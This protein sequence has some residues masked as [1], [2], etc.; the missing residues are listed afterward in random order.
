MAYEYNLPPK[1]LRWPFLRHRE[2]IQMFIHS[3]L[4]FKTCS[5]LLLPPPPPH[6]EHRYISRSSGINPEHYPE[7][8]PLPS[9][10]SRSFTSEPIPSSFVGLLTSMPSFPLP[11]SSF[12]QQAFMW[13]LLCAKCYVEEKMEYKAALRTCRHLVRRQT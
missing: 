8:C 4:C 10:S 6:Q 12:I 1:L 5:M 13:C 11:V 9:P 3:V 7:I 2:G